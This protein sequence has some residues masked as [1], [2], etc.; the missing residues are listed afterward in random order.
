MNQAPTYKLGPYRLSK[1]AD[2]INQTPTKKNVGLMD[3]TP[4]I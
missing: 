3:Q 4:T 2:L 1:S